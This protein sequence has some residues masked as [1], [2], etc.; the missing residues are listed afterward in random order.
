MDLTL[1][2]RKYI[3]TCS[4][5]CRNIN[6]IKMNTNKCYLVYT[7]RNKNSNSNDRRIYLCRAWLNSRTNMHAKLSYVTIVITCIR[8]EKPSLHELTNLVRFYW[9]F[10]C[11][12]WKRAIQGE[13]D[14]GEGRIQS[15]LTLFVYT[16]S[17]FMEH[18][19]KNIAI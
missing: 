10:S 9:S 1:L 12:H 11:S 6:N 5:C 13:V 2:H 7:N 16:A 4:L 17:H 15:F 14:G 3:S 18:M 19:G 8:R